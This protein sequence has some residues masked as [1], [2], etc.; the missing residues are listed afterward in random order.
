MAVVAGPLGEVVEAD[1][2]VVVEEAPVTVDAAKTIDR[3]D[4]NVLRWKNSRSHVFIFG[5]GHRS[6]DLCPEFFLN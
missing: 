4:R 3:S 6:K 5:S 2:A 1:L